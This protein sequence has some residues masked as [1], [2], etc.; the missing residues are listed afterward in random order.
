MITGFSVNQI[1]PQPFSY[2]AAWGI[3]YNTLAPT[4]QSNLGAAGRAGTPGGCNSDATC[5]NTTIFVNQQ[6][7]NHDIQTINGLELTWV[8]PLDF[9]LKGTVFEG[10]GYSANATFI[11]VKAPASNPNVVLG[12]PNLTYNATGYYE[13]HGLSVHLSYTWNAG[14]A[15]QRSPQNNL[16]LVQYGAAYGQADFSSSYELNNIFGELPTNPQVTFDIQN[17]FKA[18]Q[19]GW[20]GGTNGTYSLYAPG[21][22]YIFG[23]RGSL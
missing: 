20:M 4:A 6:V 23:V 12:V 14:S 8:Q 13:N 16:D 5:A 19:V 18:K 15:S 9:W 10:F 1:T 21:S 7:N 3:T 17:V 2:L 11:R 22:V